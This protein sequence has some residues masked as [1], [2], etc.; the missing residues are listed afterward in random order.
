MSAETAKTIFCSTL[1]NLLNHHVTSSCCTLN[2][3]KA[4]LLG[5]PGGRTFL[6]RF[7]RAVAAFCENLRSPE[8]KGW[9]AYNILT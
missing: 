6:T 9:P 1:F 7:I 2:T 4:D 3:T 5:F 8:Q